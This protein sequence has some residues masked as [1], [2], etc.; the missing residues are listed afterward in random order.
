M[1]ASPENTCG[2]VPF[3]IYFTVETGDTLAGVNTERARLAD[4]SLRFLDTMVV[5]VAFNP[6]DWFRNMTSSFAEATSRLREL[7]DSNLA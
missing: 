5:L 6:C 3:S 2:A 4:Y 1:K 7:F